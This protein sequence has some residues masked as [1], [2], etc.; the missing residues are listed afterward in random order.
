MN[1]DLLQGF[2]LD[3]LLV[4]PGEGLVAGPDG[5]E[6]LPPKAMEVLL[7]LASRPGEMVPRETLIEEV[8]GAGSASPD[9]LTHAVSSV[10]HALGDDPQH[11]HYVQTLPRR[12]YRLLVEARPLAARNSG[13]EPA[14]YSRPEWHHMGLFTHLKQRGVL[15]TAIAYLV[16][17]WLL[18]QFAD[19]VFEQLVFPAWVGTF[20]TA[21]VI[22]GFPIAI[23]LSWF[24]EF[25]D[26][27]AIPHELSPRRRSRRRFSRTYVSVVAA[28]G[29]AGLMVFAYDQRI[30]LPQEAEDRPRESIPVPQ[31]VVIEPNAFAVI[32]FENLDGSDKTSLFVNGLVDDVIA[33]LSRVPGL[34][35]SSRGDAFTLPPHAP[36]SAVRQR[37]R[38]AH[39]LAGSVQ[40]SNGRMR[41]FVQLI[42]S[43]S[44]FQVLSRQFDRTVDDFFTLLDEI[45]ELTVANVRVALPATAP[46]T[47]RPV[48]DD[49]GLDV[50]LL[51]RRGIEAVRNA[52]TAE[53]FTTAATWFDK[54]LAADPEY[55]AAFAG[56]CD[57]FVNAYSSYY[58]PDN[59]ERAEAA[60]NRAL[61]LN[62]NLDVVYTALGDLYAITGAYD[63]AESAYLRALE[64]YPGSAD[65]LIGLGR[66]YRA[67]QRMPEAEA[68]LR[69][70]IGLHPGDTA[71][72]NALGNFLYRSGRY[73]EAAEQF[74]IVVALD[75][76]DAKGL[77]NLGSAL[78]MTGDLA[79]AEPHYRRAIELDAP[80]AVQHSLG[81]T[82]FYLGRFEEAIEALEVAI[83]QNPRDYLIRS[84]LG[85]NYWA[86]GRAADARDSFG[87]A[88]SLAQE[89][90]NV[91]PNDAYVLMDLAWIEAAL[92]DTKTGQ[93]LIA[94][95]RKLAPE[96]PHVY[97][98][99][100][101]IELRS[102]SPASALAALARAVEHGY[103]PVLLPKDPLLSEL[104]TNREFELLLALDEKRD[105][106]Y[107]PE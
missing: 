36:S 55:A 39:Y 53:S 7:C 27:R 97:Y 70:A 81:V 15:E 58:D 73:A 54:A 9:T 25:R 44:G 31:D 95:A 105:L 72:F 47:L 5:S 77:A 59:V 56:K 87:V 19:I 101:L 68:S 92:G 100:A 41:V 38:V 89:A 16:F 23:L 62:P 52:T 37:L 85:D 61:T 67:L 98:N 106:N 30:G 63:S 18:I 76:R 65:A 93:G 13:M 3:D 99:E 20:V 84:T 83:V 1:P 86:A 6:R 45:T 40:V 79:A 64:L 10:R 35:V 14:P 26:G 43:E 71:A 107:A 74:G 50:Y 69:K 78:Y 51:Y 60:C 49:A 8:W 90:L 66:V 24:L 91:N 82:L 4:N 32:P 102:G 28:L 96:I 17:G 103:P 11:P 57:L 75:D 34:L 12:G 29:L 104:R 42:N 22:G 48:A 33:R 88:R 80:P 21:L 2:Y 46:A 94:R